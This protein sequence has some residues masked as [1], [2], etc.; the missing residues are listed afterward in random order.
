VDS[1]ERRLA[2][3]LTLAVIALAGCPPSPPGP[4][5]LGDFAG[6]DP[7]TPAG[8][9][10]AAWVEQNSRVR[11]VHVAGFESATYVLAAGGPE[12][13]VGIRLVAARST[14]AGI[15]LV[16]ETRDPGPAHRPILLLATAHSPPSR[17]G[18]EFPGGEPLTGE[19]PMLSASNGAIS[20]TWPLAGSVATSSLTVRGYARIFEATFR[21]R[22]ED[23]HDVLAG[24]CTMT[25]DGAPAWG[26]F[27]VVLEFP[28]P[29]GPGLR[30]FL[31][32]ESAKDGSPVNVALV[33]LVGA[34]GEP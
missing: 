9:L 24:V 1:R 12:A 27:E 30:L 17:A 33:P 25:S 5:L 16:F 32:E 34:G 14:G 20:V 8:P 3:V 11:G 18:V 23:G 2:L 28:A 13:A 21:L 31:F 29:A 4:S 26:Q 7:A 15:I 22:V 19:F 10:V 6:V